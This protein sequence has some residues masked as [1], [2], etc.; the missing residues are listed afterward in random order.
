MDSKC[1][2][3]L[4]PS[5]R[6]L[7]H[8]GHTGYTCIYAGKTHKHKIHIFKRLQFLKAKINALPIGKKQ[9]FLFRFGCFVCS[10]DPFQKLIP[11]FSVL[12]YRA[13]TVLNHKQFYIC[14]YPEA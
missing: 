8:Q 10:M 4:M 14:L 9:I 5:F 12:H 1:I 11:Y 7:R 3:D 13:I 2:W 6:P